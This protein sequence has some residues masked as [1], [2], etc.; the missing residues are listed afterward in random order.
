MANRIVLNEISY[1]DVALPM[2]F[3]FFGGE[4][5]CYFVIILLFLFMKVEKFSKFDHKAITM[6]QKAKA[7]AEGVEYVDPAEKLKQEE[8]EAELA[9]EEARKAEVKARCEK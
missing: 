7:A 5:I 6:D 4:T 9:S 8:A 3:I 1:H 2:T